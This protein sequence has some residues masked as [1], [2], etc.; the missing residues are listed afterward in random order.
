MGVPTRP[1]K[2]G[3]SPDYAVGQDI[4]ANEANDD[5]SPLYA[6]L[7]AGLSAVNIDPLAAIPGTCIAAAPN[8]IPTSRLNV[9]SVDATILRD[10]AGTDANRAVTRNHLRDAVI[11]IPKLDLQTWTNPGVILFGNLV[12]GIW[13]QY[14]VL[15]LLLATTLPMHVSITQAT[16]QGGFPNALA[17]FMQDTTNGS[18]NWALAIWLNSPG[19][20]V[21]N[22]PA[23]PANK[24]IVKYLQTT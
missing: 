1:N 9:D 14:V 16:T 17:S 3:G 4:L 24:I 18:I 8:G 2:L 12:S 23:I 5:I 7:N 10:D 11:N 19:N 13:I 6:L 15:P 21:L 22:P 20:S